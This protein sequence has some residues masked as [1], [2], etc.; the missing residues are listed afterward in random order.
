MDVRE[1]TYLMRALLHAAMSRKNAKQKKIGMKHAPNNCSKA[2]QYGISRRVD[3]LKPAIGSRALSQ[4]A[5]YD[6]AP[7]QVSANVLRTRPSIMSGRPAPM[8]IPALHDVKWWRFLSPKSR[9]RS[10]LWETAR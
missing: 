3:A 10:S 7:R 1:D 2:A 9:K 8:K 4:V 6:S 5:W